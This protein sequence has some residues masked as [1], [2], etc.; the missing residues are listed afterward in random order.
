M[1]LPT[2]GSLLRD[3]ART[4]AKLGFVNRLS[5]R[6]E[7]PD[8]PSFKTQI[9][10]R[11]RVW[12]LLADS[13]MGK[14][15][16]HES[17]YAQPMLVSDDVLHPK[18]VIMPLRVHFLNVGHGDC[19]IIE[20]PSGRL[21]MIDIN[22]SQEYDSETYSEVLSEEISKSHIYDS[23]LSRTAPSLSPYAN[24]NDRA[25]RELT[26]PIAYMKRN[27]PGRRLWRF[28]LTHP[29]L[30]HMRGLKRVSDEIGLDNFWD[31][32]HAKEVTSF[33]GEAD[34]IDWC[35]YQELRESGTLKYYQ[36]GG[37]A[38]AFSRNSDGSLGGDG[39][40]VL[41]PTDEIVEACAAS[42]NY[43]N[44]STV[45][46]ISHAG[47]RVLLPGD[48]ERLAWDSML[49]S[50]G[51]RLKSD[52]LKASH[53]GR[54]SGY[55]SDALKAINPTLTVVSVGKKPATDASNKIPQI[56]GSQ[57]AST[58]YYGDIALEIFDNGE[59]RWVVQ[60]NGG[61]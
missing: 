36:R 18:V 28:V 50:Y 30:D 48:A 5:V 19:S 53:H 45:I 61:K 55:H 6:V 37:D 22:N 44:I 54:D 52:F 21:T 24:V 23:V 41:S 11:F 60:R 20:H 34:R 39:I 46:R 9:V 47:R 10:R 1:T 56:T 17:C 3:E 29:D 16:S 13:G 43:N 40:E 15:R 14:W 31:T 49:A 35:F 25:K 32:S 2:G 12:S 51:A 8:V 42:K 26:D 58:R 57:V 33:R 38:Y 4:L 59:W 27:F 7:V